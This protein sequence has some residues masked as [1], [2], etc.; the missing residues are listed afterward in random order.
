M[1]TAAQARKLTDTIASL[2][3]PCE[4]ILRCVAN[5]AAGAGSFIRVEVLHPIA[6]TLLCE[7]GYTIT[8]KPGVKEVVVSW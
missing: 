6:E 4:P 8:R 7:Q 3:A 5:A 1:F 2:P